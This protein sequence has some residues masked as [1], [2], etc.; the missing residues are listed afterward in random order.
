MQR[1]GGEV[2]RVGLDAEYSAVLAALRNR[3]H[4]LLLGPAGSGKTKVVLEALSELPFSA[5]YLHRVP[6]LHE[7]LVE[8]ARRKLPGVPAA[9]TS[10]HL[11]GVLWDAFAAAPGPIVLDHLGSPGSRLYRFLQRLY[12]TPG[13]SLIA[14]ARS[15]AQ[16]GE[17]HR[18]FWDPRDAA[19]FKP[20]AERD[21]RRLF[22]AA[23]AAFG[24][25]CANIEDLRHSV[26]KT[27]RGNPGKIVE[28]CR[29]AAQ[30]GYRRDGRVLISTVHLDTIRV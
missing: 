10:I 1:F 14:I 27:A 23:A 13:M 22:D 8:M 11:K 29:L 9:N 4:L 25:D 18:L 24:A 12:H 16:L 20:L 28:M 7:L 17:L 6:V 5:L 21:A 2:A 3:K 19:V 15:R 26:L 30:P